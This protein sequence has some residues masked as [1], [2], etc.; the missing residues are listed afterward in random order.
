MEIWKWVRR[1]FKG[2]GIPGWVIVGLELIRETIGFLSDIDFVLG[3]W[4]SVS[5]MMKDINFTPLLDFI[6]AP[7]FRLY[8]IVLGFGLI[9]YAGYSNTKKVQKAEQ[10]ISYAAKPPNTFRPEATAP[11]WPLKTGQSWPPENRP[12]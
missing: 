2:W 8:A 4:N 6:N 12:P 11:R 3:K 10:N 1:T 9:L 5:K 7:S